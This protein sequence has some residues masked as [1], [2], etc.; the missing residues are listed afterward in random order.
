MRS[1]EISELILPQF[2]GTHFAIL[3]HFESYVVRCMYRTIT[4]CRRKKAP[5]VKEMKKMLIELRLSPFR[6]VFSYE[7]KAQKVPYIYVRNMK[8]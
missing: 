8:K 7:S 4:V 1:L 6:Q 3:N 5:G 2:Y